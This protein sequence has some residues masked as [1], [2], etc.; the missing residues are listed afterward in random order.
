LGALV[1]LGDTSGESASTVQYYM[2][3]LNTLAASIAKS[4]NELHY[5]GLNLDGKSGEENPGANFFVSND[6]QEINA[7]NITVNSAIQK[8]VS[9]IAASNEPN[10]LTGNGD[11]ALAIAKLKTTSQLAGS[12][13]STSTKTI[14]A[15]YQEMATQLGSKASEAK[16]NVTNQQTLVDNLSAK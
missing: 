16:S 12:A 7:A 6:G 8:D 9:K 4:V 13:D 11:A 3:K 14:N 2:D 5:N 1:K 10:N 15:F